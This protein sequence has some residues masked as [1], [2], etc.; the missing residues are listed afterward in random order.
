VANPGATLLLPEAV[1]LVLDARWSLDA[2]E[3]LPEAAGAA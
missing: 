3:H 2:L 1:E